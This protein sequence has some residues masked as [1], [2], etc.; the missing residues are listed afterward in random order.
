MKFLWLDDKSGKFSDTTLRA[1]VAF[2]VL[3]FYLIGLCIL[4]L[5]WPDGLRPLQMDIVQW[6]IVF[7]AT[8]GGLYL[9][10]RINEQIANKQ[11]LLKGLV[12]S[13]SGK[14]ESQSETGAQT[15]SEVGSV[16]L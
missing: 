6:L 11:S 2:L 7:N 8:T 9:S 12:G 14:T 1:W 4:S 16:K 10:K 13:L 5:M 15:S 3:L